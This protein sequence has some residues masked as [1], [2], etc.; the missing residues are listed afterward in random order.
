MPQKPDVDRMNA[1]IADAG[2][3][4]GGG[5]PGPELAQHIASDAGAGS[6]PPHASSAGLW[7]AWRTARA[8]RSR[9]RRLMLAAR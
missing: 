6:G 7:L 2:Y 3:R 8:V 9:L 1:V 4:I 5:Q